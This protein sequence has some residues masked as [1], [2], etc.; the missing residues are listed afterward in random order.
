MLTCV[1]VKSHRNLI[2]QVNQILLNTSIRLGLESGVASTAA[3]EGG[4]NFGT[5]LPA[6]LGGSPEGTTEWLSYKYV[7]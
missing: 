5:Y 2:K 4:K 6:R 3:M 7:Y 1:Y